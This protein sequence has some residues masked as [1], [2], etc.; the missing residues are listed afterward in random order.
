MFNLIILMLVAGAIGY[1][2]GREFK[3]RATAKSSSN[4]EESTQTKLSIAD[5]L[6]QANPFARVSA[7]QA[8]FETWINDPSRG[9]KVF[10]DW[11]TDLDNNGKKAFVNSLAQFASS[12]GMQIS[13]LNDKDL[14]KNSQA[15]YHSI[16][17]LV[18]DFGL[19]YRKSESMKN[20]SDILAQL[21]K[22]QAKP[23]SVDNKEITTKLYQNLADKELVTTKL[24][25]KGSARAKRESMVEAIDAY[26]DENPQDFYQLF[27]SVSTGQSV[28]D[29]QSFE[30]MPT[31]A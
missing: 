26:R 24:P 31:A 5:R 8:Q 21:H 9:S 16:E 29:N 15:I 30:T 12:F 17:S 25:E 6:K 18:D 22:W 14:R 2:I 27:I 10:K 1:L 3:D 23:A 11:Y 28:S 7:N 19:A 13:W 4:A 20:Q